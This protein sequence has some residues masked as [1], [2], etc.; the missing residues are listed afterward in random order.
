MSLSAKAREYLIVA[1]ANR[2]YAT[3]VADAIDTIHIAAPAADVAAIGVTAPVT[4]SNL[5]AALPAAPTKAEVDTGI[6]QLAAK[7][8]VKTDAIEAKIDAIRASLVA[9]GLML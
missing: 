5:T 6:D 1:M 7:I 4:G 9:A 8:E 2:K 3:E